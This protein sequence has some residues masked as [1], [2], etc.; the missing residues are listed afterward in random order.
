MKGVSH[1][2][3]ILLLI[4][5]AVSV[6]VLLYFYVASTTSRASEQATVRLPS[7]VNIEGIDVAV[8]GTIILYVRTLDNYNVTLDMFYLVDPRNSMVLASYKY[9]V[10]L[11]PGNV[12]KIFIPSIVIRRISL[13]D[14]S[15]LILKTGSG[16]ATTSIGN[17][18]MS[19]IKEALNRRFKKIGY[20]AYRSRTNLNANHYIVLDPVSGKF[21][22]YENTNGGEYYGYA[23]IFTDTNEIFIPNWVPWEDR[24]F[25]SPVLVVVNPTYGHRDWVFTVNLNGV[26]HRFKLEAIGEDVVSD[27]LLLWEDLYNPI[28]P[29]TSVDDWMDHVVRVSL[30]F[31]GTY[32]VAVYKAKGGYRQAFYVGLPSLNTH[33]EAPASGCCVSSMSAIGTMDCG[34]SCVYCKDFGA[35]WQRMVG[36]YYTEFYHTNVSP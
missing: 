17:V 27:Y 13:P 30:F 26:Y 21:R 15:F 34:D 22:F 28:V 11:R 24:P 3:A 19:V 10:E 20:R 35:Y 6:S 23:P 7:K 25:D 9:T 29:P 31:N 14:T 5:V 12:A 4:V 33:L 32:R 16:E 8:D 18:P 1:V 36:G 2:V